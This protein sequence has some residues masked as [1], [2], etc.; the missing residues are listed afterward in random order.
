MRARDEQVCYKANGQGQSRFGAIEVRLS[1]PR[2]LGGQ[3][4][5]LRRVVAHRP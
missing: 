2:S 3:H 1:P 4:V 5:E